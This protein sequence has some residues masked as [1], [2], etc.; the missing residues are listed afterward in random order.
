[1]TTH[2]AIDKAGLALAA[3]SIIFSL[4]LIEALLLC[5]PALRKP[6]PTLAE[7]IKSAGLPLDERTPSQVHAELKRTGKK[8]SFNFGPGFL[9][10]EHGAGLG[11][12]K[13]YPLSGVADKHV[14]LG[15]EFGEYIFYK[16]DEHGFNNPRGLYRPSGLEVA[17]IG[18]S[19]V[20]GACVKP[21]TEIVSMIRR[22]QPRTISLGKE[23]IGPL[24][25]LAILKE[26]AEPLKPKTV[27]WLYYASDLPDLVREKGVAMLR[28]YLD[29]GFSQGLLRRRADVE[30]A[31]REFLEN[32]DSSSSGSADAVSRQRRSRLRQ[33]IL[34]F[35]GLYYLRVF[36]LNRYPLS[37]ADRE[38][39]ALFLS[40]MGSAKTRVEAW[41]GKLFFVYLPEINFFRNKRVA[42]RFRGEV[43]SGVRSLGIPVIDVE[44]AFSKHPDPL[45]FF[46]LGWSTHYNEKGH[47]A[48]A[49]AILKGAF[50]PIASP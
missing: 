2:K 30:A 31:W 46:F 22:K 49:E 6:A 17:V 26:Y 1:L 7:R 35:A 19:F 39:L 13:V 34:R 28:R 20:E 23:G 24:T 8:T 40:V 37:K 44:D 21:G 9:R 18:D 33:Q 32:K 41:G 38:D 10:A 5:M 50:P 15:H 14:I 36:A 29:E 11:P 43:I 16:S 25:E 4:Y 47:A 12:S 42:D 48:V 3:V 27:F 45:S